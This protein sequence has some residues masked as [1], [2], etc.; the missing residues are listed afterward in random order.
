MKSCCNF[1]C[2]RGNSEENFLGEP[3]GYVSE[4]V[5]EIVDNYLPTSVYSVQLSAFAAMKLTAC[6]HLTCGDT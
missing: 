1:Y 3:D 5:Q 6:M 2:N 4:L